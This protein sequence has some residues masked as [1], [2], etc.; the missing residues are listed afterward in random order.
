LKGVPPTPSSQNG[1]VTQSKYA[2]RGSKG[3]KTKKKKKDVSP[4][5]TPERA[6]ASI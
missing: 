1:V 4:G 6:Q 2:A 3:N 5:Q